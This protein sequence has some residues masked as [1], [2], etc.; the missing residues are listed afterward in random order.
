M[1]ILLL[2]SAFLV[3]NS[4]DAEVS[5]DS[6]TNFHY[7][8]MPLPVNGSV[9]FEISL[10][11][12]VNV[13]TSVVIKYPQDYYGTP[14]IH[15]YVV[16]FEAMD[17]SI[18]IP[19]DKEQIKKVQPN[20]KGEISVR[21]ILAYD[22]LRMDKYAYGPN[23]GSDY[24]HL[25]GC[26]WI[27]PIGNL[28]K[29]NVYTIA[30]H[31]PKGWTGYSSVSKNARSYTTQ[32]SYFDIISTAI[33]AGKQVFNFTIKD[34]PVA[35]FVGRDL[36]IPTE[37]M[38]KA[39][40]KIVN[41]QRSW[42]NDFDQPFYTVAIMPRTGVVAGSSIPNLFVCFI[43]RKTTATK[44]NA[45]LS[46]EMFHV[47]LPNSIYFKLPQGD[48]DLKYSWFYEGFTEYYARKIMLES[49]LISENDFMSF[50]NKDILDIED[51]PAKGLCYADLCK[52][53][54][55]QR[56]M[57]YHQRI[58]YYKGA[59]LALHWEELVKEYD[60]NKELKNL[61]KDLLGI[62]KNGTKPIPEDDFFALGK[63]YGIDI[64][65][66]L[67]KY[68]LNCKP[69]PIKISASVLN[70]KWQ[71]EDTTIH[72]FNLGFN[73]YESFKTGKI[74]DVEPDGPA[75]KAGL[76]NGMEYVNAKN[77]NRFSNAY[78]MKKPVEILIKENGIEKKI[79]YMPYGQQIQVQLYKKKS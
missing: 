49:N 11:F 25:A 35:V 75:Y 79:E 53:E 77:A 51:S 5:N 66:N 9:Q 72:L 70:N 62:V 48:R 43:D 76:R 6:V 47:W 37:Q 17:G 1:K 16:S 8:I 68:F 58:A 24:F 78:N 67:E 42:V 54:D 34:K 26:Q 36:S 46:H 22:P 20:K 56:F 63:Q 13:D 29:E 30:M 50:F 15:K 14:D 28:N 71:L 3:L 21:Y 31:L 41:K 27:L 74:A 38:V 52:L 59:L 39:V 4:V 10:K 61:M 64:K 7:S 69:D 45:L 33:G 55:E 2:L 44:L 57:N 65:G 18:V 40:K 73:E 23:I 32:A 60:K 12:K 19:T